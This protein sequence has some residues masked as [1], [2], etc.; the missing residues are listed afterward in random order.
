MLT[1]NFLYKQIV[2]FH[3]FG[4]ICLTVTFLIDKELPNNADDNLIEM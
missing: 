1:L 3:H 4:N 2:F